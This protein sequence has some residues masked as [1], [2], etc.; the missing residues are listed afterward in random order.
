MHLVSPEIKPRGIE[1]SSHFIDLDI[2]PVARMPWED[3]LMKKFRIP[4][5][6]FE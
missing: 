5:G 2:T 4:V 3:S 6:K 1:W